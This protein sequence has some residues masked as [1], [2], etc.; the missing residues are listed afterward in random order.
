MNDTV[1]VEIVDSAQDLPDTL[2]RILLSEFA[3][4]ADPIEK[5]SAGRE[6]C[7]DIKLVLMPGRQQDRHAN[8]CCNDWRQT[9][10]SNQSMNFTMCS[11]FSR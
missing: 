3:L 5:L 1:P 10:D 7:D 4:F 2:R 6:L 11:C 9:L 8:I